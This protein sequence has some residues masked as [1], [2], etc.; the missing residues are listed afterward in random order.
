MTPKSYNNGTSRLA[1]L[2]KMFTPKSSR[3]SWECKGKKVARSH[4]G[5]TAIGVKLGLHNYLQLKFC[6]KKEKK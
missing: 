5:G 3:M 2:F 1:L 6:S 4:Y